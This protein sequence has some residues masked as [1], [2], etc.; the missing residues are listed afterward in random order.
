MPANF[1]L[2][3]HHVSWSVLLVHDII[4]SSL[5]LLTWFCPGPILLIRGGFYDGYKPVI[6]PLSQPVFMLTDHTRTSQGK[7]ARLLGA[8]VRGISS[9]WQWGH[10]ENVFR[11]LP[12]TQRHLQACDW[13]LW[14]YICTFDPLYLQVM[15]IT[16]TKRRKRDSDIC[17]QAQLCIQATISCHPLIS[18]H[19]RPSGWRDCNI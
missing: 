13:T 15:H 5:Y 6:K 19:S 14:N 18:F 1:S 3:E 16:R 2:M 10:N 7:V 4:H 17:V 11:P 8:L 9:L 12:L